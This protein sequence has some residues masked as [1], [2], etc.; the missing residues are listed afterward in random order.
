MFGFLHLKIFVKNRIQDVIYHETIE[1][2]RSMYAERQ[3]E[4][5][6]LLE[7]QMIP[8]IMKMKS[9]LEQLAEG[10]QDLLY[11]IFEHFDCNLPELIDQLNDRISR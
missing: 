10:D 4:F 7:S 1:T 6:I 9:S 8:F 3:A 11:N 5:E 2:L